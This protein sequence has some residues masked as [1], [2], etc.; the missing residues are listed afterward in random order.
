MRNRVLERLRAGEIIGSF[1]LSTGS[2]A[3]AECIAF[4]RPDAIVFDDQH[5]LWDRQTLFAAIAAVRD[6]TVP[7][8]RTTDASEPSIARALDNG[9]LGVIVPLVETPEQAAQ[10]VRAAKFPPLGERSGGG[11]R[12]LLDFKKYGAIANEHI[13]VGVMIESTRGV[14]NAAKIAAVPGIDMVMVGTGDLAFSVGTFPDTGPKHETAVL[15]VLRACQKAAVIP[16]CFGLHA[17]EGLDRARQGF[18][19]LAIGDDI[20][21]LKHWSVQSSNAFGRRLG[22]DSGA[23]L[24]RPVKDATVLL[25]GANGGIGT[26]LLAAL[27]A[28]GARRIYAC[29]RN[30]KGIKAGKR[31]EVL[32][33]DITDP[34]QVAA[35]AKVAG[36]VDIVINNAGVNFNTPLLGRPDAA[37]ARAEME[38][39]YFGLLNMAQAFAPVLKRNGG[40]AFVNL[41]SILAR[42]NLPLMGS[43][44]AS[45]SAA[46]SLTQAMRAE[47]AAQK[48]LVVGVMP[49][50]VDT[51]MTAGFK[52]DKIEPADVA[53]AIV[54][55]LAHGQED[56]YP[57][58]MAYEVG[59]LLAQDMKA[60]ER[61]FATML[62]G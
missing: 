37:N 10:A 16:G 5:G 49:G 50:A 54:W 17:T 14:K 27:R 12:P 58:V 31:V 20:T 19:F 60:T 42:V 26:A 21:P 56:V 51:A 36:D 29:A 7:L 28:A 11:V 3:V 38:V 13:F 41:L 53:Q 6:R 48:T 22:I 59:R 18:R 45:K 25:T 43:L 15:E 8:V 4:G 35:A 34:K 52:G 44:C 46:L 9:A 61:F 47:L 39:N 1:W 32:K 23:T 62:P 33:L 55:A 40:G 57:G 24:T 30:P 2:P